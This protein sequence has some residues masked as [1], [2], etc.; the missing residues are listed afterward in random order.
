MPPIQVVFYVE[1][2]GT[3]P[4]RVW[5]DHLWS[6]P[7]HRAKCIRW[8]TL[9]RDR[10]H[11]LRRPKADYLR[12]GIHELR[13]QFGFENYR[14]LY[15]FHGRDQAVVTHGISK[16]TN[17]VPPEEIDKALTCKKKYESNSES[18]AFDWE[19]D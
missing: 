2:D 4:M 1:D 14:M 11:D 10:G 13:V 7:K 16:H 12:E 3:V 8:L 6:Q 9:L 5:L 17:E 15:F 19:G 18:H